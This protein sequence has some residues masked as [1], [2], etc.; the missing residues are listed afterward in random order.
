MWTAKCKRLEEG[1]KM[2]SYFFNSLYGSVA[3]KG[4]VECCLT[5]TCDS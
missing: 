3:W 2:P 4:R 5:V 1:K